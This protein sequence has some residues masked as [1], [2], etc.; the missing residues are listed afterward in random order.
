MSIMCLK[1]CSGLDRLFCTDKAHEM[2]STPFL[3]YRRKV[4]VLNFMYI[5]KNR[6][7]LMNNREIRTREHDAPLFNVKTPRCEAFKRSIGYF[8]AVACNELSPETRKIDA[9]AVF[10]HNQKQK[11]IQPL[12]AIAE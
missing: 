5:R 1:V 9:F 3:S 8:G 6:T 12:K 10:K 11:A 7:D 2:T 4:H